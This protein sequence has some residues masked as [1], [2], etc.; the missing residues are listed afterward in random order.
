MAYISWLA[1][2][3]LLTIACLLSMLYESVCLPGCLSVFLSVCLSVSD[4]CVSGYILL[5]DSVDPAAPSMIAMH[6][7]H[8]VA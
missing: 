7:C 2:L 6:G 4:G 8:V 3:L 1:N 5:D